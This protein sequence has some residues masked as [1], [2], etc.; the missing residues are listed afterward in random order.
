MKRIRDYKANIAVNGR[1]GSIESAHALLRAGAAIVE[2]GGA[3]V[4]IDNS[5]LAHGG[6]FWLEMLADG[7]PDAIS[8]A[9]VSII[10]TKVEV[11]T[12]GLHVLGLPDVRMQAKDVSEDGEEVI[13]MIQYLCNG[14][15]GIGDGHIIADEDGPRFRTRLVESTLSAPGSPMH[16]PHGCLQLTSFKD[17]SE[18]N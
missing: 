1:G 3:G 17:I 5:A 2:A 14:M 16:N 11:F 8:F 13:E 4:F 6:T 7:S 10:Q 9:F 12:I 15:K 18:Q